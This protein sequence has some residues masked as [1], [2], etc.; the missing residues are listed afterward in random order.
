MSLFNHLFRPIFILFTMFVPNAI[1]GNVR[2]H[3]K[4]RALQISNKLLPLYM[5][6]KRAENESD[7][8]VITF[9]MCG[10]RAE[11]SSERQ[12]GSKSARHV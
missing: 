2:G 3:Y 9:L 12:T 1:V 10:S 7:G 4:L 5:E 8:R 6:C 11:H